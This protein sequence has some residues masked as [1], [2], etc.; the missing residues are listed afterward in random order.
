MKR[1]LTAGLLSVALAASG[2]SHAMHITNLHEYQP[3]PTAPL[4]PPRKVGVT[5]R[6]VTDPTTR[7]FV[8]A[9]AEGL[10]RD[11]SF[12][13]V[14]Y[15]YDGRPDA[16]V[17]L[18]ISVSPRYSG[19][20]SNFLVNWPGFLIF[21]PAMWGYGYEAAIETQVSIRARDG[22]T[23]ELA[24]PT[25]YRFRQAEF[26]RTWTEIG[27][28]E[29]GVIPLIGGVAFTQYDPDLTPEF[30]A[31]VAPNYGAYV[32]QRIR[33][34]LASLPAL[35]AEQAPLSATVPRS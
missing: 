6:N 34:A 19:R 2:C 23:Q 20:G 3:V 17:V 18:D 28:F 22:A 15:P 21:A 31:K 8:D 9:V 29:F 13:R 25:H 5:S 11:A 12:D 14:V 26:D 32:A 27:W 7:G 4:D 10:R 16:D 35:P 24:I 1:L 30:V 33:E